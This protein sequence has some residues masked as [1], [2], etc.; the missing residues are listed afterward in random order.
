M[1]AWSDLVGQDFVVQGLNH[2]PSGERERLLK[3]WRS[4]TADD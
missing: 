4:K 2:L 1:Q 3:E